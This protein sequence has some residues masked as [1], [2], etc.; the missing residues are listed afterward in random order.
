MRREPRNI[1]SSGREAVT[2]ILHWID[3]A[4]TEAG[5]MFDQWA[6]RRKS[7]LDPEHQLAEENYQRER[8]FRR[9]AKYLRHK[10][11]I[12]TKKTEAGLLFELTT[13]GREE[14]LRRLVLERPELPDGHVCLVVYDIPLDAG[15]GR[16]A[17]RYFLKRIGFDQVQKSVW[18][19]TKDVVVEV[20]DFV[21]T[22]ELEKWIEVYIG[23][24]E[25]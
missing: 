7:R 13:Q 22:A 8:E 12:K 10:K 23:K 1:Q 4:T 21:H 9:R 25:T 15:S 19:T 17:L 14:L 11:F 24:K 5:E 2:E 6:R 18:Q 3:G 20:L 16:D